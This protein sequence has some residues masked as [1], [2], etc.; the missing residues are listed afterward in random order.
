MNSLKYRS[1]SIKHKLEIIDRVENLPPGKRK[2]DIAQ[3]FK[4]PASTLS[5]I[6]KNKASLR[7]CHTIRG[8]NEM[9]RSNQN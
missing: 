2:K 4:I 1:I 7:K 5:T 9:Q 3:E 6:I 8:S